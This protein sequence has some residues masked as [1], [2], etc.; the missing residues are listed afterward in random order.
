M[1]CVRLLLKN[2]S[3]RYLA[4]KS[5]LG[6]VESG[7]HVWLICP[8]VA[9]KVFSQRYVMCHRGITGD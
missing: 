4:E 3:T 6:G 1:I 9:V 8:H 2:L 7:D 5:E